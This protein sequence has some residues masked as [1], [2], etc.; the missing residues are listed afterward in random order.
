MTCSITSCIPRSM[1]SAA[2][3]TSR[4]HNCGGAGPNASS[5][6]RRCCAAHRGGLRRADDLAPGAPFPGRETRG[7]AVSPL[8]QRRQRAGDVFPDLP[9]AVWALYGFHHE[10]LT[11][12][13][14][15][16]Q[17]SRTALAVSDG[18]PFA[19]R[20]AREACPAR[21]PPPR[22]PS[23]WLTSARIG[24]CQGAYIVTWSAATAERSFSRLSGAPP[25]C[26]SDA[27]ML[28]LG[29]VSSPTRPARP[30]DCRLW[31]PRSAR[32]GPP[33]RGRQRWPRD[34]RC[35]SRVSPE[36]ERRG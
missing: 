30:D 12:T 16:A 22:R 14:D 17:M 2:V 15:R 31:S 18:A 29:A 5:W 23:E 26:A 36:A 27:V 20:L 25:A 3:R 4:R 32:I 13:R 28:E 6:R 34:S 21:S 19:A 35:G 7:S 24:P 10:S 11:G 33:M 1:R 9:A 8:A